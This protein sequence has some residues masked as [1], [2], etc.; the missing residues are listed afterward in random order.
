MTATLVMP[1]ESVP[2]VQVATFLMAKCKAS[3]G[4]EKDFPNVVH[5]SAG[6]L[7]TEAEVHDLD[8]M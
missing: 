6:T 5:Q 8:S 3:M 2:C 4:H 1:K 7:S